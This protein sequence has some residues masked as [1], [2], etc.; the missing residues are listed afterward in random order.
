M[1]SNWAL[2]YVRARYNSSD[3]DRM[4]R[5]QEVVEAIAKKAISPA[6]LI[7]TP[8]LMSIYESEVES[9]IPADQMLSLAR[10]GMRLDSA[11]GVRRF[12]IGQS[13]VTG[14]TTAAGAAVLLPNTPAIQAILQEALTFK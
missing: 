12:T 14:W 1:D 4:R 9:N 6:G 3:F 13:E 7:K 2:W 5:T 11:E 10:L 8:R